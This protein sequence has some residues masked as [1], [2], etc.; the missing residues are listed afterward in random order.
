MGSD[1]LGFGASHRTG[2][3]KRA[4][5]CSSINQSPPPQQIPKGYT[6]KEKRQAVYLSQ[7]TQLH[8]VPKFVIEELSRQQD[9]EEPRPE[10]P[11]PKASDHSKMGPHARARYNTVDAFAYKP[12]EFLAE[13]KKN[14]D[15]FPVKL[16]ARK[17]QR[18]RETEMEFFTKKFCRQ[19]HAGETNLPDYMKRFVEPPTMSNVKV[20]AKSVL[21]GTYD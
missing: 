4:S 15:F 1:Q 3:A 7:L 11:T 5:Q 12:H 21:D 18:I 8:D 19:A 14:G 6:K 13:V 20:L 2:E 16:D 9:V 10:K 17:K